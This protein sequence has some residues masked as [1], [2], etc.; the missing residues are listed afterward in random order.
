MGLNGIAGGF[1]FLVLAGIVLAVSAVSILALFK[2]I[3]L[4]R[5]GPLFRR[6]LGIV[7]ICAGV[8]LPLFTLCGPS[9]LFR[10]Q[11]TTPPITDDRI[12]LVQVGMSPDEVQALIGP[13][14]GIECYNSSFVKW[15]YWR[16]AIHGETYS[17]VFDNKN[18]LVKWT[19]QSE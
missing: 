9:V 2:G 13:P 18:G 17:V 12:G 11:H 15:V 4:C 5:E 1:V 6:R 14:H 7:S 8:A 10:L 19:H 16:D 3:D